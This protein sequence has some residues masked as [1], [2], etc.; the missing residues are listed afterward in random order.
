MEYLDEVYPDGHVLLPKDDSIKR[1]TV[2]KLSNVI[3]ADIQ[4]VQVS[5]QTYKLR[6][7]LILFELISYEILL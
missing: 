1:A 3:A 5:V 4:P 7:S 2:R 6:F